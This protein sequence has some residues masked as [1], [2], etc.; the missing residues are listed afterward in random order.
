M[1]LQIFGDKLVSSASDTM[2]LVAVG[3]FVG[4]LLE[5][6]NWE[7]FVFATLAY[8]IHCAFMYFSGEQK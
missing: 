2:R 1:N 5:L 7:S 8:G 4:A 6:R 3:L